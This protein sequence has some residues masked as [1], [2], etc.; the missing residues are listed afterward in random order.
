[1]RRLAALAFVLL[2][3]C[4]YR[5]AGTQTNAPPGARTINVRPFR[6][7]TRENGLD[8]RLRRAIQDEFRRRGTLAVV[9]EGGDLVL[10]G[11]IRR[12]TAVPVAFSATD[13]AVQYQGVL[14]VGIRLAE[15]ESGHVVHETPLLQET[16][17]FGAVSG[18]VVGS[19]PHFQRGTMDPRD[20]ASLT[21]VQIG[22]ARRHEALRDLIDALARD[23]YL[24][25]MEGF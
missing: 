11:D 18:V 12:F 9:D 5:L 10:T 22:E 8:V 21:N 24:Q 1:M 20:L 19:S 16:Q 13:E 6:N 4:G 25:A 7:H 3:A 2:A 23:V 14:Q 17:D 15:R